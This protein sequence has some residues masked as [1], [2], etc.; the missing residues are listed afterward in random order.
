MANENND[1]AY[2][3]NMSDY[4]VAEGY[5]DVRGWDVFDSDNRKIGEVDGLLASKLAE[6]VVYIDVEVDEDLITAGRTDIDTTANPE[7]H[8]FENADGEDHII[9]PIGLVNFNEAA[10]NVHAPH[11]THATFAKANRFSKRADFDRDYEV[12]IYRLYTPD[13]TVVVAPEGDILPDESVVVT[14]EGGA[15]YDQPHFRDSIKN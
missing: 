8:E 15:F 10:K 1:L 12:D 13:D 11:I 3:D 14:P 7:T 9:I 6:R 4:K 5:S 2:L